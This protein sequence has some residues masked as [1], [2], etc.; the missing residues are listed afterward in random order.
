M[1]QKDTYLVFIFVLALTGEARCELPEGPERDIVLAN[2][3]GC[4][5]EKLI[6]QNRMSRKDWD[7][8]I[9]WMQ[10]TQ[11][12]WELPSDFR[13]KILDYLERHFSSSNE[14]TESYPWGKV[15]PLKETE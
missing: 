13:M 14:S 11:G 3:T 10:K 6:T 5:S 9:T 8:T 2:C 15:L 1:R 7:K 4:H 12:L